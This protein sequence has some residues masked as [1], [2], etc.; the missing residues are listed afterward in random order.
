[1]YL[2]QLLLLEAGFLFWIYAKQFYDEIL[3]YRHFSS[4]FSVK[5]GWNQQNDRIIID[6]TGGG[7]ILQTR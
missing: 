2:G 7:Y 3:W 5:S 6:E 1:M 4:D